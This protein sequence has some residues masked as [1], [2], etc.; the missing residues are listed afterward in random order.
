MSYKIALVNRCQNCD[1]KIKKTSKFCSHKC[2]T[3]SLRERVAIVCKE[4]KEV[5]ELTKSQAN[6][7]GVFCTNK[8]KKKYWSINKKSRKQ[9]MADYNAK[10][11][12]KLKKRHHQEQKLYDGNAT[13]TG[14]ECRKCGKQR[15]R[16]AIHHMDGNNGKHGKGLNNQ[17]SNLVVLCQS[18]H[19]KIHNRWYLKEVVYSNV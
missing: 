13:I 9:V 14:Q 8:C 19:A 1:D 17:P 3:D 12:V 18:C 2:Y 11:D 15:R 7:G 5:F 16:M 10:E 4:C 6:N